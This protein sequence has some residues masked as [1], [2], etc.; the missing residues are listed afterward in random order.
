MLLAA[1]TV[2]LVKR[3]NLWV[4]MDTQVICLDSSGWSFAPKGFNVSQRRGLEEFFRLGIAIEA[5]V[6]HR[7]FGSTYEF[8]DANKCAGEI[9]M[10]RERL[11]GYLYPKRETSS[12]SSQA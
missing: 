4:G 2:F 1:Y 3:R 8:C 9:E 10:L 11:S 5:K 12:E 6:L 7:M